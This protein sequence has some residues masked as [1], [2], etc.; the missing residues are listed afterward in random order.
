MVPLNVVNAPGLVQRWP[1][2]VH[3]ARLARGC[4]ASPAGT[5]AGLGHHASAGKPTAPA[6]GRAGPAS[7]VH[8]WSPVPRSRESRFQ[9]WHAGFHAGRAIRR[10]RRRCMPPVQLPAKATR[11]RSRQRQ[12]GLRAPVASPRQCATAA[13]Q[14]GRERMRSTRV[15]I[16]TSSAV[17]CPM[18]QCQSLSSSVSRSRRKT[19]RSP[20]GP[21]R[22]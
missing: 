2:A 3:A 21:C 22:H 10:M 7:A 14:G 11:K 15:W 13:T 16:S 4:P 12:Q 18:N 17:S 8:R 1:A 19:P 20:S 9:P 6:T 5:G